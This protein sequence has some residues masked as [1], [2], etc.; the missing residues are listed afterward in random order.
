MS[1][2]LYDRGFPD[3]LGR[4]ISNLVQL[5]FTI[6]VALHLQDPNPMPTETLRLLRS[7]DKSVLD[8]DATVPQRTRGC[9][10]VAPSSLHIVD[11]HHQ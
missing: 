5:E 11:E 3:A 8:A 1:N 7:G 10:E 9:K 2:P 6:R 4:L